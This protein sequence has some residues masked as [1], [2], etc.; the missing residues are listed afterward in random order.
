MMDSQWIL[1]AATILFSGAVF[2]QTTDDETSPG[3]VEESACSLW[4][5]ESRC[6]EGTHVRLNGISLY[7]EARGHGE[8]LLLLHGGGGSA[9]H[10]NLMLPE[11]TKHYRVITPDSRA[12]GRSTHTGEPLSYRGMA[13]DMAA[14]LDSL[15]MDSAY[16]GGWSDGAAIALHLAIYHPERVR[17]LLLTPVD[18]SPDGLSDL[19]WE[20]T[21]QLEFPGELETWWRTRSRPTDAEMSG[22]GVPTLFVIGEQ[23]QYVKL[24]HIAWQYRSIP[25]AEVVWIPGADHMLV[26]RPDAVNEAF[27]SF[28]NRQR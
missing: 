9:E 27:L 18:L 16:V 12:Q 3:E 24:D 21:R 11:L 25:G 22:I 8:P 2:A 20:E 23:E 26:T 1:A 6:S 4:T 19:Y 17:A 10:F 7:Y 28:L 13:E 5:T 15:G 14:L